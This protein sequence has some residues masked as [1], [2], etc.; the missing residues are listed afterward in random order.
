M[1][2]KQHAVIDLQQQPDLMTAVPIPDQHGTLPCDPLQERDGKCTLLGAVLVR[3]PPMM[4]TLCCLTQQ[5]KPF[6]YLH[7]LLPALWNPA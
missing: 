2:L 7:N 3:R 1:F 6:L 4:L 5:G